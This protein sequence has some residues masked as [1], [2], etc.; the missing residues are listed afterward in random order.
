MKILKRGYD[1]G[2]DSGVT[3]YWLIECK[4]LFSVVLLKFNK[5]SREAFH[6][7]AFNAITWWLK[8]EVEE[9]FQDGSPS[10]KW[11]PSVKP[12]FTIRNNFHKIYA[13][14][15]SWAISFRGPWKQTWQES[16]D[17][18]VY[19]LTHGRKRVCQTEVKVLMDMYH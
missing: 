16:K 18:E 3:G 7:H 13:N 10:K 8:G 15:V 5:G 12:K 1:G 4:P 14:K 19:N 9:H 2:K 17:G 6:S 11:Y